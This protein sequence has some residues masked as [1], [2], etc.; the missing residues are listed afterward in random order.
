MGIKVRNTFYFELFNSSERSFSN[1]GLSPTMVLRYRVILVVSILLRGTRVVLFSSL[2]QMTPR[3]AYI[4]EGV[5]CCISEFVY[6]TTVFPIHVRC[7][8][9]R[10]VNSGFL[11]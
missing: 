9:L 5:T 8:L 1:L 7:T 10:K 4:L 2:D 3:F 11:C 6:T